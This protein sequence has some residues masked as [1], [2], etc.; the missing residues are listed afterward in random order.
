[1]RIDKSRSKIQPERHDVQRMPQRIQRRRAGVAQLGLT[2][3]E[4]RK[5]KL[6]RKYRVNPP[7]FGRLVYKRDSE[8]RV[9]RP[10][11]VNQIVVDTISGA[12]RQG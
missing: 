6:A 3:A 9:F 5:T 11:S 10:L 1:M 8:R 7:P 12:S 4:A 2:D